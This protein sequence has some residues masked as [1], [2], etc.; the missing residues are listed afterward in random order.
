MTPT[1]TTPATGLDHLQVIEQHIRAW[2]ETDSQARRE[3][4]TQ[5]AVSLLPRHDWQ[6]QPRWMLG[7]VKNGLHGGQHLSVRAEL[8]AGVEVAVEAGEIAAAHL[9]GNSMPLPEEVAG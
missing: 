1:A 6:H 3:L 8:V 5:R 4:I 9:Q 7:V 2:N